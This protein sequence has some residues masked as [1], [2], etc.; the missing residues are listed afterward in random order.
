MIRMLFERQE[1]MPT[2]TAAVNECR[3]RIDLDDGPFSDERAMHCLFSPLD[4]GTDQR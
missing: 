4:S 3:V 1:E 2:W